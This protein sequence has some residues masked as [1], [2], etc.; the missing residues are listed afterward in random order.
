MVLRVVGSSPISHPKDPVSLKRGFLLLKKDMN[1]WL[2]LFPVLSAFIGWL[3]NWL[4]IRFLFHPRQP[5]KLFGI[6]FHG[7][8]PRRQQQIA[9]KV[10]NF[11]STQFLSSKGIEEKISDPENV[12]KIMPMVESH[13]DDFLRHRLGKEMPMISMFIG[14]KTIGRMKEAL[15]KEIKAVFPAVMKQFAGNFINE[16]DLGNAVSV[17]ISALPSEKLEELLQR[18]L[19]K[20]FRFLELIGAAI[21]FI[22]GVTLVLILLLTT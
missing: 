5:K 18:L 1:N 4:V 11:V 14:E 10:G 19:S 2:F 3:A 13:V 17:K 15:M 12:E 8:I 6:T 9:G 7:V 16:F 21:G 20:E 22:I